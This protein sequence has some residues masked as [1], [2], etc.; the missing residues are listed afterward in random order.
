[1]RGQDYLNTWKELWKTARAFYAAQSK[2]WPRSRREPFELLVAALIYQRN[3]LV[4]FHE[5]T[6]HALLRPS[7]GKPQPSND[8]LVPEPLF[9]NLAYPNDE[10]GRLHLA[11]TSFRL[12]TGAWKIALQQAPPLDLLMKVFDWNR[13]QAAHSFD[14]IKGLACSQ[15]HG[16]PLGTNNADEAV[17]R[18]LVIVLVHRD[19]FSHGEEGTGGGEDDKYRR[20][21][22]EVLTSLCTCRI[23]EAQQTLIKWGLSRLC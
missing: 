3:C 23:V 14:P 15:T 16:Q 12:L 4:A 13:R 20:G 8:L 18:A 11:S 19:D 10:L 22:E 21:R 7:R 2:A 9:T 17:K 1:M 5:T 6:L